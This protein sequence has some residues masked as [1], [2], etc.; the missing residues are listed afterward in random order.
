MRTRAAELEA[1]LGADLLRVV[2]HP[3]KVTRYSTT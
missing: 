2:I 1:M 3:E